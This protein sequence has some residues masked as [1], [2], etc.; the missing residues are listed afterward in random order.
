MC[1]FEFRGAWHAMLVEECLI[2][3]ESYLQKGRRYYII[4]EP[5]TQTKMRD[6][7]TNANTNNRFE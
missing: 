1:G 6:D 2:T 3:Y 7:E 5:M 4:I